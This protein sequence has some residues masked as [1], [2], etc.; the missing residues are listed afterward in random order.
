M[1]GISISA[2]SFRGRWTL[3]VVCRPRG[4]AVLG[5]SVLLEGFALEDVDGDSTATEVL[6]AMYLATGAALAARQPPE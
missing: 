6:R 2:T 5:E 3:N 4:A 1:A